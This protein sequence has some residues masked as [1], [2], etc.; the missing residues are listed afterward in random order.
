M[1]ACAVSDALH[2]RSELEALGARELG[3]PVRLVTTHISQVLVGPERALKL[4][5]PVDLGFLDFTTLERRRLAC[6]AEVLLNRRLAPDVY[7]AVRPVARGEGGALQLAGDSLSAVDYAVEMRA[8]D[9]SDRYDVLLA[10]GQ[11]EGAAVDALADELVRF[12]GE[13]PTSRAIAAFGAPPSVRANCEENFTQLGAA[14]AELVGASAAEALVGAAREGL[15]ALSGLMTLRSDGGRVRD[16]HGDLRLEHV[17]RSAR[18]P[19]VVDCIEFNDRFRYAD[20][21]ADVA[22]LAMDLRAHGRVDLAERFVARYAERSGDFDLYRLL[23]FYEAYRAVVRA[24]IAVFGARAS[25]FDWEARE[26]CEAEARRLLRLA[27]AESGRPLA[28]PRLIAVG[29]VIASGKSTVAAHLFERLGA[30]I[31]EADRVR[32]QML[33]LAARARV[34][35]GAWS[36]AYDPAFT[37]EVY[38]EVLR[39]ARVVLASG[40]PVIVDASF[41]SRSLRA[42]A[43][44]AALAVGARFS[45]VECRVPYELCRERLAARDRDVS[46]VSDGRS[47]IFDAFVARYEPVDELAADEHVVVDTRGALAPAF[48]E[49]LGAIP[50]G[51]RV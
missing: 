1:R 4:K 36:G 46:R 50:D 30:P 32:K 13:Q 14:L 21:C 15:A 23:A 34:D 24:K 2:E 25:T 27:V 7:L 18:G 3:A 5:K 49:A 40:R 43:R 29:G 9:D 37:D 41:R 8:L 33:G 11:L 28:E 10:R 22:F 45:F 38:R 51:L 42:A 48:A 31:V 47:E 6:E 16:G 39:R 20:V 17:Y 19:V 44:E 26:R 35:E 12:H